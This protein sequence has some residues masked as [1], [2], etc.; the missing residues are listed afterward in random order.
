MLFHE[1][2]RSA[3]AIAGVFVAILLIFLQLGFYLSVPQGG[4]LFYKAMRFDLLLTS[5]S[6]VF[7]AQSADFP[8]GR[9]FQAQSLSEV[10]G[11]SA[12]Y[13]DSALWLNEATGARRDIF[14][15][16]FDPRHA[17]FDVPDIN[18]QIATV[19]QQDT[20]LVDSATRPEFGAIAPGRRAEIGKRAVTI[21]GVYQLGVG[22]V[23]LG[24][25]ITSDT[26]FIRMFPN[27]N[28]SGVNLGLVTLAAGADPDAVA[29][30]LRAILPADTQ[31]LTRKELADH[32]GRHWTTRTSTGLIFGFG[33]LVAFVVGFV[34]LN[35]TLSTQIARQLPQYATL[36]AMG[37]TDGTL[38]AIVATLA[39]MMTTIS[40]VPAVA[41]ATV[42]YGIVRS[43]T[44]LPVE[45]T[46]PRIIAVLLLA[47]AMS[48]LSALAAVRV[49]RRAEPVELF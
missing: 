47:W 38:G 39:I 42:V 11:A 32:E 37:Y 3:L 45:M 15:I 36:K 8:R 30:R 25:G 19:Q 4:M 46:T 7:Q 44:P 28:L 49:L 24:V 6:Y 9:L 2:G 16:A 1:K 13:H 22:F 20:I 23:G 17:V 10:T 21:G 5:R 26:N 29:A 43:L 27:R 35:Q 12:V 40:Y 33:T 48:A 41:L 34:I 14:V 18:R 31:V